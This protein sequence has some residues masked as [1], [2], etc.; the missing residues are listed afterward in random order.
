MLSKYQIPVE[1]P[2]DLIK[3]VVQDTHKKRYRDFEELY[4]YSYRVASTVGLMSSHIL[5]YSDEDALDYAEAM[6]IGMQLTNILRDIRE[7]AG[8]G[9]I[10][11]PKEDLDRF[12]IDESEILSGKMSERFKE[13]MVFQISRA[14]EYYSKGEEGIRM[15]DA[16]SRFTVLLA[17]RV[18]G[19][20]LD[21]IE[22]LDYDVFSRRASTS[23]TQ[24][25]MML[26]RI[27]MEA[28]GL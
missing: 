13:M 23:K 7:D 16:D 17:S 28:K 20:I 1:Y 14:R 25:F 21:E 6:G 27:W 8:R 24:K 2:L 10:Y 11:I 5:G 18:Y 26:P 22:K 12:G 9:R 4:E 15:L 19:R 3:G